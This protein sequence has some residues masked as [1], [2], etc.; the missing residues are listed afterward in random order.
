MFSP[1]NGAEV[2]VANVTFNQLLRY[3]PSP[4]KSADFDFITIVL[5]QASD[6]VQLSPIA[7]QHAK[8]KALPLPPKSSIG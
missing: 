2:L 6:K 1:S 4:S 3:N 5:P 8:D 7:F